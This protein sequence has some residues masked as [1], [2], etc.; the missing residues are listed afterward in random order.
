MKKSEYWKGCIVCFGFCIVVFSALLIL[1][2][3]QISAYKRAYNLKEN[4]R[5]V[6]AHVVSWYR[7]D[8]HDCYTAFVLVYEYQENEK[9]WDGRLQY[10]HREDDKFDEEYWTDYYKSQIGNVVEITIYDEGN[11]CLLTS[12]VVSSYKSVLTLEIVCFSIGGIGLPI[13]L[14]LFI[15]FLKSYHKEENRKSKF[16]QGKNE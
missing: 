5:E 9:T 7:T 10:D 3:L 6:Q 1:A 13:T 2:F 14:I 11:Y 8:A 15:R 4:G 12:D 16:I